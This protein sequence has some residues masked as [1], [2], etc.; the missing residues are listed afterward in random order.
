MRVN[1]QQ[2]F[3]GYKK[4]NE[5]LHRYGFFALILTSMLLAS[6]LPSLGGSH[7]IINGN[8]MIRYFAIPLTYLEAGLWCS[9]QSLYAALCNIHLLIFVTVFIYILMPL[10]ARVGSCLLIY[11]KVNTWLLKGMEVFY[12]MPP[13]FSTSVVLTRVA[14]ADLSTSVVTTI[15]MHFQGIILSPVLLYF[16]LGASTPP[17]VITD[18]KETVYSTLMP[19]GI[20]I[21]LQSFIKDYS[22][23]LDD[24]TSWIPRGLLLL[25]AYHWFCDALSADASFLHAVDILLCVLIACI[26]QLIVSCVCWVLCS[27]WLSTGILLAAMFTCTHKS[28]S[29]GG[30][31]LRGAYHGS[32]QGPAVNLPLVILPVA[33]LLLGSLI[34]SWLAP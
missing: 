28:V 19:L 6:M 27:R 1:Y 26:G 3:S 34:A 15:V 13:P 22:T 30:W 4:N 25:T 21:G 31:I 7:G 12:C 5:L 20:G 32:I 9:P 16:M 29:L 8:L 17:L 2:N 23:D 33:Q 14:R 11:S 10:L 24:R 18:I